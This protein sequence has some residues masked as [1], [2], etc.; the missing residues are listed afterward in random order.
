MMQQYMY[1]IEQLLVTASNNLMWQA[2]RSRAY[3]SSHLTKESQVF[4]RTHFKRHTPRNHHLVCYYFA[5]A[6]IH[7]FYY[8]RTYLH[9]YIQ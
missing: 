2:T 1:A 7:I 8:T 4:A 9:T 3:V 6:S 5:A